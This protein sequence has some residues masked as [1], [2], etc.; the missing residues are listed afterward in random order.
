MGKWLTQFAEKNIP[1]TLNQRTDITDS[2]QWDQDIVYKLFE[3][4]S[5]RASQ[6]FSREAWYWAKNEKS[7]LVNNILTAEQDYAR[8]YREQDM[9][10]CQKAVVRYEQGFAVLNKAFK[11]CNNVPPPDT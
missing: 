2:G 5:L 9:T 4:A 6:V 1:K 10:G 7:E 8:A 3:S 11:Q